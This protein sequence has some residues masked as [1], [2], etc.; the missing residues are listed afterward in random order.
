MRAA[1]RPG[2]A[3]GIPSRRSP[4]SSQARLVARFPN[5]V[6]P[7]NPL[8][9]WAVAHAEEVY[10]GSLELLAASGE[11]DVLQAQVDLSQFRDPGSDEWTE[12]TLRAVARLA[13]EH[14]L[15][16]VA[17]SV[18]IADPPRHPGAGAR[19]RS[20]AAARPA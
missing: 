12:L 8:D 11:Y 14:D 15:F 6:D 10:P 7:G 9:C 16:P 18:H 3:A 4:T 17:T 13:E 1:R 2:E 19:A 5:Y 20:R